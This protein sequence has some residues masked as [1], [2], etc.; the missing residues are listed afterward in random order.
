MFISSFL[1]ISIGDIIV[2][3]S[4]GD[5]VV[6]VSSSNSVFGNYQI[7]IILYLVQ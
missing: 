1:V 4:I 5:I 6:V 2:V 3:V 7:A